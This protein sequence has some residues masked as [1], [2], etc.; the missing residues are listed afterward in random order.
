MFCSMA[1]A[2]WSAISTHLPGRTDNE[3]KN[4]WN[5]RLKKKLIKMG[6]DPVTHQPQTAIISSLS[7]VK[8][9]AKNRE[10]LG[11]QS[12]EAIDQTGKLL[13]CFRCV[14]QPAAAST[15]ITSSNT[16]DHMDNFS[17][18]KPVT[19]IE[20]D[21][22]G[23]I[24]A[25]D[26]FPFPLMLDLQLPSSLVT[27]SN[28]DHMVAHASTFTEFCQEVNSPKSPCLTSPSS[29]SPLPPP[30]SPPPVNEGFINSSYGGSGSAYSFWYS[31]LLGE[32]SHE[33]PLV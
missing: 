33:A 5:S 21:T 16:I 10:L 28:S 18:S 1:S 3:I 14:L 2:R 29:P 11:Q 26:P 31:L 32:P 8:D 12:R 7:H 25:V 4:H 30:P 20:D 9:Q 24:A 19:V 13:N 27:T 17:L 22:S 23:K 15:G 6:Y